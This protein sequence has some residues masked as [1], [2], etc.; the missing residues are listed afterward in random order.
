MNVVEKNEAIYD[1]IVIPGIHKITK[2]FIFKAYTYISGLF[3]SIPLQNTKF[4]TYDDFNKKCSEIDANSK[5]LL[6]EPFEYRFNTNKGL[7]TF[8]DDVRFTNI[9]SISK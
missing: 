2:G 5:I 3:K 6:F 1:Y 9:R 4:L 7:S 8:N